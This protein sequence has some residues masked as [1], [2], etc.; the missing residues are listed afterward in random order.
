LLP[1]KTQICGFNP[2]MDWVT[3]HTNV[4]FMILKVFTSTGNAGL[5]RFLIDGGYLTT[6]AKIK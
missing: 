2:Y 3:G 4:K 5:T 6:T 1:N